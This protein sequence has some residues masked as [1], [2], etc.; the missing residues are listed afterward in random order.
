MTDTTISPNMNLPVPVPSTAPGPD[1]AN[2]IVADMYVIDSHDHTSGKGVPITPDGLDI[3]A[4]LPMGSNN[5]TEVR[6]V[7]FTAQVAPLALAGDLGCIYVSGADL[8]Y[9]D[10]A[11]NQVRITQGGSVTGSTGTITG[12]PSGTAS[13]SY[14]AGTFTFQSATSTPANMAVG[15]IA[16]GRNSASSKTVTL[17]PN[18]GQAS[19]YGIGFPAAL[20]AAT[21]YTTLDA[22]GNLSFNSSGTTGSGAV[23]L[24]TSPTLV[25]P[26]ISGTPTGN[27]TGSGAVVLATSPTITTP[28]ISGS[29]TGN[30]TGTGAVVLSAAPTL[31]GAVTS[32]GTIEEAAGSAA[33]PSY[34]FTGDNDTGMYQVSANTLGLSAGG[35]NRLSLTSSGATVNGR[36]KTSDGDINDPA[37]YFSS[38]P[39]TG[40][41]ADGADAIGFS[42]GATRAL[43]LT[44]TAVSIPGSLEM[45][46]NGAFKVKTFTGSLSASTTVGLSSGGTQVFGAC[47]YFNISGSTWGSIGTSVVG[48]TTGSGFPLKF[49]S[50]SGSAS[51]IQ[52]INLDSASAHTY[53]AIVFYS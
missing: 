19:N 5:L 27:V 22:S 33:T 13:A 39:N 32:S 34:A 43:S 51:D 47:G 6:S 30:V 7:N 3:S 15:P 45:G 23:V 48:D 36:I 2:D 46:G 41:Y 21:N 11:G 10:E 44:A 17:T 9:N 18:A 52:I 53:Y 31:T 26:A 24:A 14:S 42:T 12:L 25:T 20:P 16:I 50:T 49:R 4:D 8:Y 37:Y 28:A 40:M 35:T 38:D 1:W 29:P